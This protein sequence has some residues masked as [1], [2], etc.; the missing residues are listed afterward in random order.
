[1]SNA[2]QI[3]VCRALYYHRIMFFYF[4]YKLHLILVEITYYSFSISI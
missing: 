4:L 3:K 1:M 2:R